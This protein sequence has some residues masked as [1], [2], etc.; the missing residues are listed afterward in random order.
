MGQA[1]FLWHTN[2]TIVLQMS[3]QVRYFCKYTERWQWFFFT[4]PFLYNLR[5]VVAEKLTRYPI[6]MLHNSHTNRLHENQQWEAV[7]IIAVL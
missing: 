4:S 2:A 5:P 6:Q 1:Y 3:F 7:G